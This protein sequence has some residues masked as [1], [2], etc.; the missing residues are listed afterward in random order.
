M[1]K[2]GVLYLSFCERV[3]FSHG[4]IGVGTLGG[5]TGIGVPRRRTRLASMMI[6]SPRRLPAEMKFNI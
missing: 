4:G 5:A 1:K 2:N 3:E 6:F